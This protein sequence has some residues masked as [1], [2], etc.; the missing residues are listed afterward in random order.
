[1]LTQNSIE[2]VQ[3]CLDSLYK[4]TATGPLP[5]D[6]R[7]TYTALTAIEPHLAA[8]C[9]EIQ[10]LN[11]PT[12]RGE[13]GQEA[14]IDTHTNLADHIRELYRRVCNKV[15][16]FTRKAP[17]SIAAWEISPTVDKLRLHVGA[18]VADAIN[19]GIKMEIAPMPVN[20]PKLQSAPPQK[21]KPDTPLPKTKPQ[22]AAEILLKYLHKGG[23]WTN[24]QEAA[25][26][27][28]RE[29]EPHGDVIRT[30][31]KST[32]RNAVLIDESKYQ[33][34]RD[35]SHFKQR[36]LQSNPCP[37]QSNI[38]VMM[39]KL[40]DQKNLP[41]TLRAKLNGPDGEAWLKKNP[42]QAASLL[43]NTD[44]QEE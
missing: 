18:A 31:S 1:M 8:L 3:T 20:T 10:Q 23:K 19:A 44:E 27:V 35:V 4:A 34:L 15:Y 42:R 5:A 38:R 21:V 22:E 7:T 39:A 32:A 24:L 2:I 29:G 14:W 30:C 9:V 6:W 33:W 41:A 16:E 26:I 12:P 43:K 25:E 40:L 37:K 13:T 36:L 17:S 28:K 11:L